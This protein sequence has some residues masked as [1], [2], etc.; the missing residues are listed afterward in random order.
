MLISVVFKKKRV[1]QDVND[2]VWL[3]GGT[4]NIGSWIEQGRLAVVIK[5]DGVIDDIY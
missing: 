1:V 4:C 3:A 5:K 2:A